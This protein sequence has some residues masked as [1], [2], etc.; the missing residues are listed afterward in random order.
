MIYPSESHTISHAVSITFING[1]GNGN[2]PGIFESE[3]LKNLAETYS[4][5]EGDIFNSLNI[6]TEDNFVKPPKLDPLNKSNID[7]SKFFVP[8]VE[9]HDN[10][11]SNIPYSDDTISFQVGDID[12]RRIEDNV[13]ILSSLSKQLIGYRELYNKEAS[14]FI[15]IRD[16]I[17]EYFA[18]REIH[19]QEIISGI[20][21]LS[22]KELNSEKEGLLQSKLKYQ[23]L[24]YSLDNLK[25]Q[26]Y[27]E[28]AIL[29]SANDSKI[30]LQS[31]VKDGPGDFA[32]AVQAT[33][34]SALRRER[35][36]ESSLSAQILS[37]IAE[38]EALEG[39]IS[40]VT[41]KLNFARKDVGFKSQRTRVADDI[42]VRQLLELSV[43]GGPMNV[44]DRLDA[45]RDNWKATLNYAIPY[46]RA[47]RFGL[48]Y[49]N[50]D[51]QVGWPELRNGKITDNL[52][53]WSEE[54]KRKISVYK[55]REYITR[56]SQWVNR[57]NIFPEST[58]DIGIEDVGGND[59]SLRGVS[60]EY[61]GNFD[62]PIQVELI[63]PLSSYSWIG[64]KISPTP[65]KVFQIGRVCKPQFASDSYRVLSEAF[66]NGSPVGTWRVILRSSYSVT[67]V[68]SIC[69]HL[70]AAVRK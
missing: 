20:Y 16:D 48:R 11:S 30:S 37:V 51:S 15:S 17:K 24:K 7:H 42:A 12:A 27:S 57:E 59:K 13:E 1:K 32:S 39:R 34:D 46:A 36:D 63:P 38:I 62:R 49:L 40:T 47:V 58:F 45:I 55:Q 6:T 14:D 35:I 53:S 25:I 65:S 66:W 41:E 69:I 68:K 18:L 2:M 43:E 9:L 21:E 3:P 19:Q 56:F 29:K 31:S 33:Y 61:V 44:K 23:D 8:P 22:W 64:E 26:Y 52:H 28:N 67:D 5:S 50:Y 10:T 60:L 70:W 54:I 4:V